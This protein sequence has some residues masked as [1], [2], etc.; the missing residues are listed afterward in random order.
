M[1][2]IRIHRPKGPA[3]AST[4]GPRSCRPTRGTPVGSGPR[5]S[6][7]PVIA[8]PEEE[9]PGRH[10]PQ[11]RRAGGGLT[12]LHGSPGD[13]GV[14]TPMHWYLLQ[15]IVRQREE[16]LRRAAR[17]RGPAGPRGHRPVTAARTIRPGGEPTR[18]SPDPRRTA[19][20]GVPPSVRSPDVHP[21]PRHRRERLWRAR[22]P[23][24]S[25]GRGERAL[26]C[27]PAAAGGT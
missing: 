5:R 19:A 16:D 4:A 7:V 18:S 15:E 8:S 20:G 3:P 24:R 14:P 6:P 12:G 25:C 26:R 10:L 22:R 2:Q 27:R 17:Q 9:H 11:A 13:Q 21:V 23:D 1:Q